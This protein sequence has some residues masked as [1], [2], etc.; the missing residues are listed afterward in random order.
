MFVQ[1]KNNNL[2]ANQRDGQWLH[3]LRWQE[4]RVLVAWCSFHQCITEAARRQLGR[5]TSADFI[6][7][8]TICQLYKVK[9]HSRDS[10]RPLLLVI[11]LWRGVVWHTLSVISQLTFHCFSVYFSRIRCFWNGLQE[12]RS[13]AVTGPL[14]NSR[15]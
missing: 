2:L 14:K 3:L 10:N 4:R 11:S 13:S 9:L 12:T 7:I 1:Q 5:I 15:I 8:F 6:T